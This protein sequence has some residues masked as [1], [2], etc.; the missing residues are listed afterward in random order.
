ME[1]QLQEL[2]DKHR[3]LVFLFG[4]QIHQLYKSQDINFI[5]SP[6]GRLKEKEIDRLIRLLDYLDERI[7]DLQ[8]DGLEEDELEDEAWLQ[9][10]AAQEDK[11]TLDEE[12]GLQQ[13]AEESQTGEQIS[14]V[15]S[16]VK[17]IV[18]EENS[19]SAPFAQE[20]V[21]LDDTLTRLLD[22]AVFTSD[23]DR[24]LFERNIKQFSMGSVREREVALG[25]IAHITPVEVLRQV[26]EF[27]MKDESALVRM[28][29]MK[30]ISRMKEGDSAGFFEL[31]MNDPDIKVRTAAIKG[32]GSHV[33]PRNGEILESLLQDNDQHI[34]GLAVT[35][36]GIYYGKEGVSK[37]IR[38]WEDPS[39]FVRISLLEMLSIVK[40][41]GALRAVKN[42]LSDKEED[43]KKAAEKALEKLMPERK[44]NKTYG[45]RKK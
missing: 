10:E 12:E 2:K 8:E 23:A 38:A 35:Y 3:K 43:V 19:I 24:R 26:Y 22:T 27:A 17:K 45:Q 37:A 11:A 30:S 18:E 14:V 4:E 41:E 40:P 15:E 13:E 7:S 42:L 9:E 20:K 36:L 29:V 1:P 39:S 31:G 32:L 44:R 25:Q 34:R 33:S 21:R 16:E 6:E 28:A 5:F